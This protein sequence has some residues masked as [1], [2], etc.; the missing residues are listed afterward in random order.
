MREIEWFRPP[1]FKEYD[2]D[3]AL[4]KG[5]YLVEG[6]LNLLNLGSS[7]HR[8]MILTHT[9]LTE[10]DL[11]PDFQ[12]SGH[13]ANHKVHLAIYSCPALQRFDGTFV[14]LNFIDKDIRDWLEGPEEVVLFTKRISGKLFLVSV[15]DGEDSGI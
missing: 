14:S 10:R 4:Y 8:K 13:A 1:D 7:A 3:K 5:T 6:T 9:D 2:I 15:E 12:Y 11:D